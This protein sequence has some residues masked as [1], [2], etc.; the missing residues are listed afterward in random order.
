M[1]NLQINIPEGYQI[2]EAASTFTNIVF[3]PLIP[4][5]SAEERMLEIWRS[6]N[7][8][9]YSS[10]N[11][12]TYYKDSEPMFQQ[13]WN[14][15]KLWYRYLLVYK[16]FTEEYQMNEEAINNLVI[17]TLSKDLNCSNLGGGWGRWMG[18]GL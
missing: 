5:K 3:K 10:D 1:K 11:S 15:K 16:I 4:K 7:V 14:N 8:V 2:D 18:D 6:C 17:K 9:R 12:R 13:D